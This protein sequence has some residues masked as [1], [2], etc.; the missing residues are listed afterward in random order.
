MDENGREERW[1]KERA[2]GKEVESME[3]VQWDKEKSSRG[4]KEEMEEVVEVDGNNAIERCIVNIS[5]H[6][7]AWLTCAVK[8]T[9]PRG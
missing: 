5:V 3:R 8:Y 9:L 2:R 7:T 4:R 6:P 1:N